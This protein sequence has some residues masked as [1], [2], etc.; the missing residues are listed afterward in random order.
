M[1]IDDLNR[2]LEQRLRSSLSRQADTQAGHRT[3]HGHGADLADIFGR[4]RRIRRRRAALIASVAAVAVA[5]IVVPAGVLMAAR[6]TSAPPAPANTVTPT[7]SPA[8]T[9]ASSLSG[10]D[11][12]PMGP[13]TKLTYL[14]PAGAMHHG[15]DLP[16]GDQDRARTSVSAF[17]PYHGGWLVAYDDMALAQY[18]AN[19]NGD[20]EYRS[21]APAI[22]V[23]DDGTRTAWQIGHQVYAGVSSGTGEAESHWQIKSTEGLI[24]YLADGPVVS[25]GTGYTVL[26]GPG[27]RQRIASTITPTTVSQ[28][29]AAVGG[30]VGTVAKGDQQGAL[31]DATTG[32]IYWKGDWTPLSF[33][34]DG[35]YVAAVPAGDNGD[36]S[37]VAILDSRTGAVVARTPT[38]NEQI[39]LG[40]DMAWDGDHVV[41]D[42]APA[43]GRDE[44]A[45]VALHTDG[46][47]ERVSPTLSTPNMDTF[48]GA[49][50]FVFMT[51]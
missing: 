40:K 9:K 50:G 35:T 4:A 21:T 28:A 32:A 30:V 13:P 20:T 31:A 51:R 18:D 24:G 44:Q 39:Y 5:A 23:S 46:R 41:F 25:D 1:N 10:L 14:D 26:T 33:S 38:L 7:H 45:L 2:D 42:V 15:E 48:A 3:G 11:S 19:G 17:A 36:P 47:F 37:A 16:A 27:L 22:A 43:E 6:D 49:G 12:I 8:H 29:A 34:S